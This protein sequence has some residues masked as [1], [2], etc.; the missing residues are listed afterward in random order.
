MNGI[1]RRIRGAIGTALIWGVTGSVTKL[2]IGISRPIP[3]FPVGYQLG[4]ALWRGFAQGAICG[5]AF[6]LAFALTRRRNLHEVS[7]ARVT[8]LGVLGSATIPAMYAYNML[9][10]PERS[11]VGTIPNYF[12]Q[13]MCVGGVF[14]VVT[15]VIARR[16]ASADA[17]I[18][19]GTLLEGRPQN[20][21]QSSESFRELQSPRPDDALLQPSVERSAV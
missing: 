18:S 2:I 1:F 7:L 9:T 10:H 17:D 20:V 11:Y 16:G 4:L 8:A 6:A 15:L 5:A 12:L 14:A 13:Y 21:A 3:D 19:T